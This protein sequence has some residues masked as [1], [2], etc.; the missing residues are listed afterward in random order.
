M[1]LNNS[2]LFCFQI[3]SSPEL[4]RFL[5][6]NRDLN[7]GDL[8]ISEVPLVFGPRPYP[9]EEGPIP[10]A[11]CS[12]LIPADTTIRCVNCGWQ[13]CDPACLGIRNPFAHAQECAVLC[14]RPNQAVNDV[15]N[16]YR[17]DVLLALRCLLLQRQGLKKW[18][19]LFEFETHFDK[20]GKGTDVYK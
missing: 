8:I 5:I 16:F 14:L 1:V 9:I 12:R 4:G 2:T 7:P 6:A 18:K 19:Q 20:R 3:A 17:Q 15:H 13:L 11:G 10:C